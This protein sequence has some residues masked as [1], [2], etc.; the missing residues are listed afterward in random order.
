MKFS[1]VW[2]SLPGLVLLVGCSQSP[3]AKPPVPVRA[4]PESN[5]AKMAS[6]MLVSATQV[7]HFRDGLQMFTAALAKQA[8]PEL[9]KPQLEFLRDKAHLSAKEIEDI[10]A[11]AFTPIDAHYVEAVFLFRDAAASL[12]VAKLKP[13]DQAK[14]VFDWV[15]RRVLLHEQVD[16]WLPPAAVLRRGHGGA[17]DRALVFL[18]VLRQSQLAGCVLA[19]A[20]AQADPFDPLLVGV[21]IPGEDKKA[22]AELA[23]FDPRL[24]RA[25]AGPG[26]AGVATLAQVLAQ[27]ELLKPSE[28]EPATLAT[29]TLHLTC[30]MS[31]LAPRMKIIE[32]QDLLA[33]PAPP[34]LYVDLFKLQRDVSEAAG[35]EAVVW[36][37]PAGHNA[38]PSPM[39]AQAA[40]LPPEEGGT[41]KTG[42]LF[43][44]H[45]HLAPLSSVI[46]Q[47]RQ[48]KLFQF[49]PAKAQPVFVNFVQDLF[50]K[51][52]VEP[53]EFL[54]RGRYEHALKRI[55]RIEAAL[56]DEEFVAAF[57]EA[58]FLKDVAEWR[59]KVKSVYAESASGGAALWTE[60]QYILN[61]LQA[62]SD[63]PLS[64]FAK[65]A[66]SRV[67]LAG[68][69]EPLGQQV[70]YLV[71]SLWQEKAHTAAAQAAITGGTRAATARDNVGYAWSNA[72]NPWVQFLSQ[73]G[74]NSAALRNRLENIRDRRTQGDFE[75]MVSLWEQLH[76]DMHAWLQGRRSLAEVLQALGNDAAAAGALLELK[77][78]LAS[79]RDNAERAKPFQQDL[80]A[81]RKSGQSTLTHRMELLARDWAPRGPLYWLDKITAGK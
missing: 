15:M 2:R 24:G 71:A 49:L 53:E 11:A 56:V 63:Q 77:S 81:F 78:D 70:Q 12:A 68:C 22:K 28:I 13:I 46:Q 17:R 34:V 4:G 60:D 75:G 39:R 33:D 43:H 26:K 65:Q 9:T 73:H 59:D 23:L 62:D 52:Y 74:L 19:P 41:D 21:L 69:K 36:N 40:F 31:A 1:V 18:E 58:V 35:R 64:K 72:R 55:H 20:G 79:L 67:L 29:L 54:L 27:P 37:S 48:W 30:P 66:L 38:P 25:V 14:R 45:L 16:E 76:L 44:Y 6:D 57:D 7:G 32:D 47:Y 42:R 3:P 10:S 61:L 51:Y 80:D 50:V 8:A 5:P